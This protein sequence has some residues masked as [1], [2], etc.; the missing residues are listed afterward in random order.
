RVAERAGIALALQ[1]ELRAVN[2]DRDVD[3]EHEFDV[4]GLGHHRRSRVRQRQH[5]EHRRSKP[6]HWLQPRSPLRSELS[7]VDSTAAIL[8]NPL[9]RHHWRYG[10]GTSEARPY[11]RVQS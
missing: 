4:D 2:A 9:F 6:Q 11:S 7:V 10:S 3:C 8:L 5:S 1:I